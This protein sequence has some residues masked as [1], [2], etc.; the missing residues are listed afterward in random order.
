[1]D[2]DK[3]KPFEVKEWLNNFYIVNGCGECLAMCED[4]KTAGQIVEALVLLINN[5]PSSAEGELNEAI[6]FVRKA[7]FKLNYQPGGNLDSML[8]DIK[9]RSVFTTGAI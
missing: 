6:S 5:C 7:A 8:N 1:M 3:S 4:S 9:T 2:K